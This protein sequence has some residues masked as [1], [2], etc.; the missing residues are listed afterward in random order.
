MI[1]PIIT[2]TSAIEETEAVACHKPCDQMNIPCGIKARGACNRIAI[3]RN[4]DSRFRKF[5]HIFTN[6]HGHST[7]S[8]TIA[9]IIVATDHFCVVTDLNPSRSFCCHSDLYRVSSVEFVDTCSK[10]VSLAHHS[11][12]LSARHRVESWYTPE[13]ITWFRF[14]DAVEKIL[15]KFSVRSLITG[16]VSHKFP[17]PLCST[18]KPSTNAPC[19]Y[20][21]TKIL[22]GNAHFKALTSV[23]FKKNT[24]TKTMA[25]STIQKK[26]LALVIFMIK[27]FSSPKIKIWFELMFFSGFFCCFE[28]CGSAAFPDFR[29]GIFSEKCVRTNSRILHHVRKSQ[30]VLVR[31]A[32]LGD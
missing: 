22:F 31:L 28:R 15:C 14:C 26:F 4:R 20:A 23:V 6:I 11:S 1:S 30:R 13:D 18:T 19:S 32:S 25:D 21:A 8:T 2:K 17:V 3:I 27:K 24:F 10:V 9:T 16:R 7:A 5:G 12:H 29:G